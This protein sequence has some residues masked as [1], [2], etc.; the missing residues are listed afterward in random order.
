VRAPWQ[1][2]RQGANQDDKGGVLELASETVP[3]TSELTRYQGRLKIVN[4][5]SIYGRGIIDG[6]LTIEEGGSITLATQTIDIS[7]TTA[8]TVSALRGRSF[9]HHA[10]SQPD[11][12]LIIVIGGLGVSGTIN[13]TITPTAYGQMKSSRSIT[14]NGATLNYFPHDRPGCAAL[15]VSCSGPT[16]RHA[17]MHQQLGSSATSFRRHPTITAQTSFSRRTRPQRPFLAGQSG[18]FADDACVSNL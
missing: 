18:V 2:H 5:G 9:L 15:Y 6:D 7:S 3:G 10:D 14:I 11:P 12:T 8:A 13:E 1:A 4:H 16:I 17:R